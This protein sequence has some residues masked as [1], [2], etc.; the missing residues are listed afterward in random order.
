MEIAVGKAVPFANLHNEKH[1]NDDR[2]SSNDGDG[3]GDNSNDKDESGI[4]KNTDEDG[5]TIGW[6]NKSLKKKSTRDS[7]VLNRHGSIM[8]NS[9]PPEVRHASS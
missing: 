8:L 9:L 7:F 5:H 1:N 2:N 4:T 3:D 6:R